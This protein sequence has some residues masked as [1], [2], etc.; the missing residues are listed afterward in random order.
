[1]CR[2]AERESSWKTVFALISIQNVKVENSNRRLNTY[3]YGDIQAMKQLHMCNI[4]STLACS[5]H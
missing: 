2:Q 1:M 4:I 5:G 3:V